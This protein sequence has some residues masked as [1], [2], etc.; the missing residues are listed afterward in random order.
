[1]NS[2][3]QTVAVDAAA[4]GLAVPLAM[5][6]V[7]ASVALWLVSGRAASGAL[8][9]NRW[10]GIRTRSTL[11]SP[12]AWVAAHR[13]A[14]PGLRAAAVILGVTGVA[15]GALGWATDLLPLILLV[16]VALLCGAVIRAQILGIR[17]AK[18]VNENGSD[19]PRGLAS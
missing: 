4:L 19:L 10:A 2:R 18:T 15:V 3:V 9:P 17:A 13:A 6:L 14:K 12:A 8:G 1:M 5:L 11:A 16:G 7:V